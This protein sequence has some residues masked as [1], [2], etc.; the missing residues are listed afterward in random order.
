[1]VHPSVSCLGKDSGSPEY[2]DETKYSI[3]A[4]AHVTECWQNTFNIVAFR[5]YWLYHDRF[6][7]AQV[8]IPAVGRVYL[9]LLNMRQ[10]MWRHLE[11]SMV[12]EEVS[13]SSA[14][15][16]EFQALKCNSKAIY[17]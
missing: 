15:I 12:A 2:K 1:M 7:H 11:F 17:L 9:C 16:G 13:G 3:Q 5:K 8:T 4:T 14:Q 10:T 6:D